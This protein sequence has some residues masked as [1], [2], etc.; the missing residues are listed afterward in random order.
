MKSGRLL[1]AASTTL[2]IVGCSIG[3]PIPQAT[4]YIVDPPAD[5]AV[6]SEPRRPETL[7]IGN[8]R[9][10]APYA[11]S[12]LVYRL[13]DVRYASD[14]YH[15]FASDPGAMLRSRIAE[16]LDQAGP[17]SVSQPGSARAAPYVLE[18]IVA[19]LYGD[20][21]EGRP[22]AAVLAVQ[23]TLMEQISA[24]SKVI[25][26]RTIAR[27][28]DLPKASPDALVRGYGTAL[29]EILSQAAPELRQQI[30]KPPPP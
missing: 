26:E 4:T 5:V 6:P 9:V 22:P 23:F 16:W 29:A 2:I 25:Y 17:F 30:V 12:A 11:G 8:V 18:A 24:R 28:V 14:P 7:R 15:T 19:E 10:A 27:R 21:R 1:L 13:D 3:R 20:F